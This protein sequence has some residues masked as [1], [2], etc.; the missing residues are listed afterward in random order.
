ME[1]LCSDREIA[2]LVQDIE[3]DDEDD[4]AKID[5]LLDRYPRDARL[6]FMR[7]SVLA[8]KQRLIEAHA[9]LS[10]TIE[11]AP[12]FSLARY[13]LGFFELTSGEADKAL[14][15]WGPL[16]KLPLGNYLRNFVEG[17]THLI[18]DEFADAIEKLQAG[19]A[20]NLENIPLN[21]DVR[22]LIDECIKLRDGS[23]AVP[24]QDAPSA[25]S[26]LLGQLSS[27]GS[28]RH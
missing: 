2:D 20:L 3:R 18:R 27:S 4:L 28:T 12:E 8:G 25:T 26:L 14:S 1:N 9:A 5:R 24:D 11:I 19:I 10:K 17:L 22:L 23:N 16:L 13:Q 21:N 6:H 15:T 7:G